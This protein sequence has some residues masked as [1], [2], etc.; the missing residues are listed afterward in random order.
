MPLEFATICAGL[1]EIFGNAGTFFAFKGAGGSLTKNSYGCKKYIFGK[2]GLTRRRLTN[3]EFLH[4]A[5]PAAATK[6][7]NPSLPTARSHIRS[8]SPRSVRDRRAGC[9]FW[10]CWDKSREWT[11]N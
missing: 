8:S 5:D 6:P 10:Y 11:P 7:Q 1:M 2:C 4:T 3:L 9:F